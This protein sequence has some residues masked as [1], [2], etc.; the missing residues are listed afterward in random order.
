M[1]S[2]RVGTADLPRAI[3]RGTITDAN[4]ETVYRSLPTFDELRQFIHHTLCEYDRLE[5][6]QTPLYAAEI[7]KSG[8]LCGWLFYVQGPRALRTSAIWAGDEERILFYGS[9]GNRYYEVRL[10]DA[11]EW[12]TLPAKS[13][14]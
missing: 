8:R 2:L 7:R 12:R 11:P 9:T 1:D 13:A 14:A 5:P 6:T 3:S 10:T 4:M